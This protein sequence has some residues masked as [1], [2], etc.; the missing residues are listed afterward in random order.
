MIYELLIFIII[1]RVLQTTMILFQVVN[2]VDGMYRHQSS[3]DVYEEWDQAILQTL[4]NC[5]L[6][7][8]FYNFIYS[9]SGQ[10]YSFYYSHT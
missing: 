10:N 5:P 6:K 3:E 8:N 7:V 2:V 1:G 9:F 4:K